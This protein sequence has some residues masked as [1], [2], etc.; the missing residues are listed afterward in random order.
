MSS[1]KRRN[2]APTQRL[3]PGTKMSQ[4]NSSIHITSSGVL[5]LDDVL[6]GGIQLGAY[7]LLL[8]PDPHSAH[9]D[10]LQKYFISQGLASGHKVHVF[11]YE[12]KSL[13]ETCMWMPGESAMR[14][15]EEDER[16]KDEEDKVKIAWRY[17]NMQ[18]FKTTVASKDSD[19]YVSSLV[20]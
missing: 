16:P 15:T 2:N 8:N 19:Q 6:G 13:V 17:E 7:L 4:A 5:S 9:T 12:A 1:F 11:D 20:C 18:K 3:L 14:T 10:L